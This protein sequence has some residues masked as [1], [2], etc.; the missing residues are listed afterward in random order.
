MI[1]FNPA[2]ILQIFALIDPPASFPFLMSAN[3]KKMD[4]KLIAV[5]A[6]TVAFLIALIITFIGPFLF[7]I[8]GI[9]FDSFR[10]AGGLILLLLG[11]DMV[12]PQK[13]EGEEPGQIN[14]LI[15]LIATPILTGP[16]TI[17]FVTIKAYEIGKVSL[18][19]NLCLAFLVVGIVLFLFSLMINKINVTVVDIMSRIMGLFLTAVA[20]EMLAKGIEGIILAVV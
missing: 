7:S 2:L 13:K 17:S 8:F 9:T 3:K 11:I 6:T 12:R 5:K 19:I 14:S 16:A 1:P 4:V 15:T 10:I 18:L 20:I